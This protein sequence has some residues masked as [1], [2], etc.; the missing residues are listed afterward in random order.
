VAAETARSEVKAA[1]REVVKEIGREVVEE[2]TES[3]TRGLSRGAAAHGVEATTERLARWWS[4]RLAGGTYE[5]LRRLP[6]ALP[7]LGVEE[8]TALG[9]SLC[10]RAGI[11]LSNWKPLRFLKDGQEIVRRIPPERGLKYLAAQGAQAGVGV[12]A[13]HKMEEHLASRRPAH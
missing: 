8:L 7:Q 1:T 5:V 10:T 4:V 11:R 6:E 13:M 12:V 2:G 9:Q 3:A